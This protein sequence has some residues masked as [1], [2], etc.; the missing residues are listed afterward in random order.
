MSRIINDATAS[1]TSDTLRV[2]RKPMPEASI[3]TDR[4]LAA[5]EEPVEV[6]ALILLATSTE[7]LVNDEVRRKACTFC[8]AQSIS[9]KL[10]ESIGPILLG[11][12]YK[13]SVEPISSRAWR[14]LPPHK[15]EDQVRLD[16]DRSF[17]YYPK[18]RKCP[19]LFA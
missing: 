14:S 10:M 13:T 18:S 17:V 7:G 1:E 15:D 8:L 5:C 6:D 3:K 12:D 16:V 4:I 2:I 11:Y 9:S 19:P